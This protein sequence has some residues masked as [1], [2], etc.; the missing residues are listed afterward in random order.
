HNTELYDEL[1]NSNRI[2]PILVTHEGGGAFMADAMSRASDDTIGALMIVPAAGFTHA[3][4]GIGE[5][6]LDGV[7]M[8]VFTGGIRTDTGAKYQLHD[9]D[10]MA[11][12]QPLT[13]GAF[14]VT[15]H[16]E[17]IPTIYKAYEI[18]TSGVP[19]PV[20]VEIPVNLQL[21][22]GEVDELP[23]WQPSPPPPQ[24]EAALIGRIADRL[25]GASRPGLF[26]GW[27]A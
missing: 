16:S 14:R 12:A 18:A 19:G 5:A 25:L 3:A 27:G 24:P 9:L 8:L 10:Q 4:S 20:L 2:T 26:V 6:F 17:I 11:L 21:F 13:E 7:A 1:N 15:R 23:A 22:T